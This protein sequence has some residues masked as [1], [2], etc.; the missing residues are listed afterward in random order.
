MVSKILVA[1]VISSTVFIVNNSY[2][3]NDG[4]EAINGAVKM[5]TMTRSSSSQFT[6]PKESLGTY[7]IDS[8]GGLDTGCSYNDLTINLYIPRV[9]NNSVLDVSGKINSSDVGRLQSIGTISGSA[10]INMPTYDIDGPEIDKVYFNGEYVTQLKGS[11][12]VWQN[13]NIEI[14]I[15]TIR[16]GQINTIKID[17]DVNNEGW[18]M[19]VDWVSAEFDVASPVVLVHGINADS[20]T[21]GSDVIDEINQSGVLFETV[22]LISNGSVSQ[23]GNLLGQKIEQFLQPIKSDSVHIIAHSKGGLDAQY[24]AKYFSHIEL[25]S[26][27]TLATPHLGSV[28]ADVRFLTDNHA[29]KFY[30]PN[31]SDPKNILQKYF[32]VHK[33]G[34]PNPPGIYDLTTDSR[35]QA[36]LNKEMDNVKNT[37]SLAANA[38]LNGNKELEWSESA[39]LFYAWYLSGWGAV[40]TY[41]IMKNYN[42]VIYVRTEQVSIL[43]TS[44]RIPIEKIVNRVI[45]EADKQND[46]DLHDNDIVVTVASALPSFVTSLGTVK[47]NHSTIKNAENINKFLNQIIPMRSGE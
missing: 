45:Y 11:N 22:S 1:L 6:P 32:Q 44:E 31:E 25:L 4:P 13:T 37:F 19:S 20:T 23:N 5:R 34:G 33:L 42:S 35:Q 41:N 24:M 43:D 9:L 36:L 39:G 7:V 16:F 38:D 29:A 8:G 2:A 14:P 15:D 28:T 10:R 27:S 18:C 26:L 30:E 17:V 21:W 40:R 47:A 46:A 12:N 3:N